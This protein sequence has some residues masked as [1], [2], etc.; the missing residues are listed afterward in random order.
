MVSV[1]SK[2]NPFK[3]ASEISWGTLILVAG[4]FVMVDAVESIGALKVTEGWLGF[5]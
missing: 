2:S 4:L 3:L 5:R 1:K